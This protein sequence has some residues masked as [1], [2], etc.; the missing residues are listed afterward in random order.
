MQE[1]TNFPSG[2]LLFPTVQLRPSRCARLK[3]RA[4]RAS[5][6]VIE[7][8]GFLSSA[9]KSSFRLDLTTR[10]MDPVTDDPTARTCTPPYVTLQVLHDSTVPRLTAPFSSLE[11]HASN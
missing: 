7:V 9:V 3:V 5:E 2:L 10:K 8:R 1:T 4:T 6:S 11:C